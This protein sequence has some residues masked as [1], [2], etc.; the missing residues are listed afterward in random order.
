MCREAT[1]FKAIT[2][3]E[4]MGSSLCHVVHK[5]STSSFNQS[6]L[7]LQHALHP[8]FANTVW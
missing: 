1:K 8:K 7:E 3:G 6:S 2:Q 5:I 4:M